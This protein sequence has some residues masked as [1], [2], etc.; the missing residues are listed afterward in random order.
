MEEARATL[1]LTDPE[2]DA[3]RELA[4]IQADLRSERGG[5]IDEMLRTPYARATFFV[6]GLGFL[7]QITGINAVVFYSPMIFKEM[8][9]TGNVVAAAAPGARPGRLAD[10]DRRVA[11]G[12]RPARTAADAAQRH[13]RD[14]RLDAAADRG[15]RGR[16]PD[17]DAGWL[18]FIGVFVFTAG[19][20]FGF[21]SLV[22]VYASESF[23]SR[24]RYD[25]RVGD[26]DRRP[27]GQPRDRA[28]L[29][30]HAR[31]AGR[32]RDLRA[33]RG[34]RGDLVPVRV[35]ARA[36]D[37]G[38]AAGGDPRVLGE[39]RDAG[40]SRSARGGSCARSRRTRSRRRGSVARC[41]IRSARRV[42]TR[43]W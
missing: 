4:E 2:A 20:N 21:G 14:V 12:R 17:E 42:A 1:A 23:P 19:F 11:V 10:R 40:P 38:A 7:I 41:G 28:V 35:A 24:L 32:D 36:R 18:G 25:R 15:V 5:S 39:R 22:W 3:D 26:A 16:R 34:A 29:P 37:E 30:Q 13:R 31:V 27:A 33:V 8:G 43:G 6:V 9:F